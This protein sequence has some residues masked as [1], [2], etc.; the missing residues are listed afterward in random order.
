MLF[1][2]A[3]GLAVTQF[4]LPNGSL[5]GQQKKVPARTTS[6]Q[7]EAP[8]AN[9]V[10]KAQD[11]PAIVATVDGIAITRDDLVALCLKRNGK[12][13]LDLV[14][15]RYLIQQACEAQ[16]I[17]I[18]KK[19][20][21]D[22]IEKTAKKFNLSSE[23]FIKLL[24][25]QR[26]ISYEKYASDVVWQMMALRKLAR[27]K[28]QVDPKEIQQMIDSEYGEK[29]QV[30]MIAIK[31]AA[32][33]ADIHK[34][35]KAAP[36]TFKALAKQHSEDSA[37]A[38][39]EGLLPPIRKFNQQDDLL[40]QTSF[41]LQQD[42]ISE[43]FKIG[44]MNVMLQCVRRIPGSVLT[45][46]QLPLVE[47]HY[48]HELEEQHLRDMAETVFA[49]LRSSSNVQVTYNDPQLQAQYPGTAAIINRNP[50]PMKILED[51][52]IERFGPKVLEVEINRRILTNA[53]TTSNVQVTDAD[54]QAEIARAADYFGI[55]KPDGTPDIPAWIKQI[56][57]ELNVTEEIYMQD[58][59]WPTVALKKMII[60]Q[61]KVTEDDFQK[62]YTRDYG[63]RAEVL[64]IVCSNQR[65]A[66]EAWQ[67][68]RDNPSEQFFGQLAAQYSVEPT[69]RANMGKVPP[70]RQNGS[71]AV[72]ENAAF[73]LKPGELSGIVELHKQ[74]FILKGQGLTQP[75]ASDP[76][77]VRG[78][79]TK[80]IHEQKCRE[81][82]EA[83]F[84]KLVAD[85]S[86]DNFLV[87][88]SQLGKTA[89]EQ[90][91]KELST[92]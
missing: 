57:Q 26:N 62:A 41:R 5:F 38:S 90:T 49:N 69:S 59:V 52:C 58:N 9:A 2:I 20:V 21:D 36:T 12:E 68:A 44:D 4:A 37:S 32:K 25:D 8:P 88:K 55:L 17:K 3:L 79:L 33:A 85:A 86:I 82:M 77:A 84:T 80:D 6:V 53:L 65:T 72:L 31:D 34:Q 74:Y 10:N 14:L 46:E 15:N 78:E 89:S 23:L 28:I 73:K 56:T 92:R 48:R 27:D 19:D 87:P 83:H 30:R 71:A 60:D 51:E 61:V 11:E 54:M 66:Q 47:E 45:A 7:R 24:E 43:I 91:L 40:E 29:V 64:V 76:Q 42:Q 63:P 18:S 75:V 35:A 1:R 67:L 81:A 70:I 22:E 50:V 39:V 16:N 13:V